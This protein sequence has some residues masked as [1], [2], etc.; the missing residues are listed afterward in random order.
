MRNTLTRKHQLFP[1]TAQTLLEWAKSQTFQTSHIN[2]LSPLVAW[3]GDAHIADGCERLIGD[4][5]TLKDLALRLYP[6][7]NCAALWKYRAEFASPDRLDPPGQQTIGIVL[8]DSPDRDAFIK[9]RWNK[10]MHP[11]FLKHGDVVVFNSSDLRSFYCAPFNHYFLEL[12]IED[13]KNN[14]IIKQQIIKRV[15]EKLPSLEIHHLLYLEDMSKKMC[16]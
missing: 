2:K 12:R 8:I 5:P 3:W 11:L 16:Q 9:M 13:P 1:N 15:V 14:E 7:A 10:M 4:D 6:K